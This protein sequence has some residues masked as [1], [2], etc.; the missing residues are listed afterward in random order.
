MQRKVFL[1]HEASFGESQ[2]Q[3][4]VDMKHSLIKLC[5]LWIVDV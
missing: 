4:G 1:F 3:S 5:L 2:F